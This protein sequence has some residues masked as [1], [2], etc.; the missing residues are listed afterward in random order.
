[1][2]NSTLPETQAFAGK[3]GALTDGPPTFYDLDIIDDRP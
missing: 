2:E 3:L 1:M